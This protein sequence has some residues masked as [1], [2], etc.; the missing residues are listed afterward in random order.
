MTGEATPTDLDDKVIR[1]LIPPAMRTW[2][3]RLGVAGFLFFT[4]KGIA[5]LIFGAAIIEGCRRAT[6]DAV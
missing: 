1:S 2:L 5:W 4:L 3:K 6:S